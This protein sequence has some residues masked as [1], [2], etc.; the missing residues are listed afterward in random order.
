MTIADRL[1]N[2]PNRD[3]LRGSPHLYRDT[4]LGTKP[5]EVIERE[6]IHISEM[7]GS[8]ETERSTARDL[9][10]WTTSWLKIQRHLPEVAVAVNQLTEGDFVELASVI[11]TCRHDKILIGTS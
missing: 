9:D 1:R 8:T 7:R 5:N 10:V 4:G 11:S 6:L 2:D 3:V